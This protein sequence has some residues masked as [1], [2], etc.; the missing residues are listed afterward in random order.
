M[1]EPDF[2]ELCYS[3]PVALSFA[4]ILLDSEKIPLS[5]AKTLMV[6]FLTLTLNVVVIW[7]EEM[8]LKGKGSLGFFDLEVIWWPFSGWCGYLESSVLVEGDGRVVS[9]EDVQVYGAHVPVV[10]GPQVGQEVAEHEG[11]DT[12]AAVLLEHAQRQYVRDLGA[13]TASH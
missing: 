2:V 4:G 11:G 10:A 7:E 3:D 1:S 9:G 5:H 6:F 8:R 13:M 12:V